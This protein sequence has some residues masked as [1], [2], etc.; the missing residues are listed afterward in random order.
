M[1]RK[2]WFIR[3]LGRSIKQR[4]GRVA[5]ASFAVMI[6]VAVVVGAA[7]ISLGIRQKLGGEL[8]AYG[9]NLMIAPQ[10]GALHLDEAVLSKIKTIPGVEDAT[11][12]L[13]AQV[14]VKGAGIELLGMERARAL[15]RG[16]KLTGAW[17]RADA[18]LI[19]SSLATALEAAPGSTITIHVNERDVELAI[20]GVIESGGP[21]DR[22]IIMNLPQAQQM[23]G[24][25]GKLSAILARA[26][27][28]SLEQSSRDIS[29]ALPQVQVRTLRQ[30][31]KAEESFLAKVE[32]LMAMVS[33]VVVVAS[34]ISVSSTMQATVLERLKEIGLMRAIGGTRSQVQGFFL[35][36]GSCIGALGGL[37][38]FI[39]G[40]ASAE[41]VSRGA[42]GSYVPVPLWIAPVAL[43]MGL[44]IA[45]GASFVPLTQA[46]S[47][48][49]STILRGE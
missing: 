11:G 16:W 8:K 21:E 25:E 4:K 33:V 31:A 38:G 9:A 27:S 12:Q 34:V 2:Q 45:V 5:V 39:A 15:A 30:V 10:Q 41:V 13:Y 29:S 44:G 43:L 14:L 47:K 48:R 7:G 35:A 19:G 46:L 6:A 28:E 49:P 24:A 20:D 42:F 18:V 40:V 22:A 17:D 26:R 32:L 1:T 37:A 23:L 36:E 3:F